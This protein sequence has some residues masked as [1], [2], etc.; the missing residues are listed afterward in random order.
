MLRANFIMRGVS[1]PAGTHTI[2]FRFQPSIGPLY[3]SLVA[4]VIAVFL[5]GFLAVTGR[6]GTPPPPPEPKQAP[7]QPA[8]AA[9]RQR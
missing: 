9:R 3:V 8:T 7:Q 2:E 5:V 1:V 6:N 4:I